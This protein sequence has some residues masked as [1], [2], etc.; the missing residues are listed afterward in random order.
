MPG[1][2]DSPVS[3]SDESG[4]GN[5][6]AHRLASAMRVLVTGGCRFVRASIGVAL[7]ARNRGTARFRGSPEL[8]ALATS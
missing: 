4:G 3:D 2:Y 8:H 7:A 5:T 1:S 6:H